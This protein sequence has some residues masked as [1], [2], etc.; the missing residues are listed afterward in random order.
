LPLL[1][2]Q[3]NTK[4]NAESFSQNVLGLYDLDNNMKK[5]DEQKLETLLEQMKS[6]D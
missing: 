3:A 2:Q 4:T 1:A 5:K 6:E